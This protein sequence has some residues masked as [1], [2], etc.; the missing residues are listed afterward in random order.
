MWPFKK[1][2]VPTPVINK[3]DEYYKALQERVFLKYPLGSEHR[4]MTTSIK[5]SSHIRYKS[6]INAP[7]YIYPLVEPQVKFRYMNVDGV[8]LEMTCSC[9]ELDKCAVEE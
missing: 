9:E 8:I 6:K 7:C 5:V 4:Y 1:K 2:E 3:V